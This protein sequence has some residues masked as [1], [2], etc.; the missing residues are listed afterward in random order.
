[1]LEVAIPPPYAQW[2]SDQG[3]GAAESDLS[4]DPDDDG[5]NNFVEYSLGGDPTGGSD[6]ASLTSTITHLEDAG[7]DWVDYVYRLRTDAA[8]HGLSYEP[9]HSTTLATDS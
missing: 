3:L 2:A 5:K 7:T 8:T 1:M 4:L 6:G 9:Q